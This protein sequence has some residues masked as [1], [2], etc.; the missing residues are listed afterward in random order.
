MKL[1]TLRS[2][3]PSAESKPCYGVFHVH[4][5]PG[6]R[7]GLRTKKEPGEPPVI[8]A[9]RDGS[10]AQAAGLPASCVIIAVDGKSTSGL[11]LD[12]VQMMIDRSCVAIEVEPYVQST[13]SF[14]TVLEVEL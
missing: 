6:Q 4:K 12:A 11:S 9:V 8:C 5:A 1:P 10:P 3:R 13:P 14:A 7:L 2:R